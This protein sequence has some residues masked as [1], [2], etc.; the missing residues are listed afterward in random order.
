MPLM[1]GCARMPEALFRGAARLAVLSLAVL[2]L[3]V[4][5]LVVLTLVELVGSRLF[6]SEAPQR[7]DPAA[8][9]SDHV[10]QPIPEYATGDLCLFCHRQKVGMNWGANRHYLTIRE[11]DKQS[12]TWAALKQSSAKDL[13]D[14]IKFVMGDRRRQR[15]L[16]PAPEYGKL[17]LLTVEWT[18]P[19]A[20]ESGTL[21]STERPR[22]D[23]SR[24]GDSC[25]GCHSTAVE[26]QEQSSSAVSLDC[27]V[28]H[29]NV[30]PEHTEKPD[31]V[32]LSP[33]RKDDAR[34]VNSICA[35]CHVRTGRSKSTGRPYPNNF[36]AGDNLFRDFESGFSD[37]A[38]KSLSAADRHV[39]EN[40][41]AVAVFG[42]DSLTCLSCHDIHGR[43]SQ[44]HHLVPSSD[45]CLNCHHAEG[46]KRT[47]KSFSTHSAT[48][49]Y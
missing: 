25:A 31:L 6:S 9:G 33:N 17:E 29:G 11:L 20:L 41:R 7:L 39:L 27:Y 12:P 16:K 28:C 8:W 21:S 42:Q 47:L 4:L 44:K 26:S 23:A 40:V 5:T 22:W 15:F 14:E 36:V 35:Q 24:F 13:A 34:V 48:C 46:P 49:G 43:S 30:P 18:P 3:T 2:S 37:D 38:F 45:Y 32:H 1:V 10:G 19:Q